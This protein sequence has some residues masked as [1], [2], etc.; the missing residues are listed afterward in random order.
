MFPAGR[1]P[2]HDFPV[3]FA[4]RR[5]ARHDC[6]ASEIQK[7]TARGR[8][9]AQNLLSHMGFEIDIAYP[10]GLERLPTAVPCRQRISELAEYA[11]LQTVI[12][13]DAADTGGSQHSADPWGLLNHH[14]MYS[15]PRRLYAGRYSAR[16]TTDDQ[17]IDMFGSRT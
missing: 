15:H 5:D 14:R 2:K 9:I 1:A 12:A 17:N 13:V 6:L 11:A 3:V 7:L 10:A 8:H 4:L 16:S